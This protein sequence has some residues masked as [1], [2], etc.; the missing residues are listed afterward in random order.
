VYVMDRL[1]EPKQVERVH[2]F[3]AGT[4]KPIWTHAYEAVYRGVGYEAGP[5]ACVVIHDG[6][7]YT[8]GTMGHIFC[9][10]AA[11]GKVLWSKDAVKEFNVEMPTW[12]LA[13]SPVVFEDLVIYLVGGTPA[14]NLVAFDRRPG[15]VRWQAV[16][17]AAS[18][19][20]PTLIE[21]AESPVLVLWAQSRMWGVDPRTGGVYWDVAYEPGGVRM[22]VASPVRA[23]EYL[24]VSS[25]F[26]G[27]M[28]VETHRYELSARRVWRR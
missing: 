17:D 23:G 21:Q 22:N 1:T 16:D 7:A 5:R 3:D 15:E 6:R 26:D 12:G 14:S 18:Y 25:F 8:L 10:D 19:S 24:F 11:T 27:A 20:T 28:L 9:L 4:G 2:C 13:T